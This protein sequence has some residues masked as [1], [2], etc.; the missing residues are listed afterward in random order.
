MR[1]DHRIPALLWL[2]TALFALRVLGQ[3]VQRWA[4]QSFLPPFDAFQGS[5]LPYWLLLSTQVVMLVFMVRLGWR[6]AKNTLRPS[7]RLGTALA[8]IGGVYMAGSLGRIAV[9]LASPGAAPWFKAWIPAF[10]HL[11]LAAYVLCVC[12]YHRRHAGHG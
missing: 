11:V 3:A 8:W 4:A 9:G 5:S 6:A 12:L 7:R 2:L 1:D 10:F